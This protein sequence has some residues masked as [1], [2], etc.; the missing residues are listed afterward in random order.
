MAKT[1]FRASLRVFKE[2]AKARMREAAEILMDKIIENASL[3][4]HTLQQLAAMGYPYSVRDPQNPHNPPYQIHTQT[5]TLRNNI[6]ISTSPKGFRV[7]V[8]VDEDKVFYIPYLINGTSKMI[9]RDFITGSFD[10]VLP[11][12]QKVFK[13]K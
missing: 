2:K 3:T 11:E 12:M 7:S 9:A 4:D 5:L 6:E 10:E 13:R 1:V 8:G